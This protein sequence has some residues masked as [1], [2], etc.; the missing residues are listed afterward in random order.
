MVLPT[1][2]WERKET[3]Q[4]QWTSSRYPSVMRDARMGSTGHQQSCSR[5]LLA[6]R[7]STYHYRMPFVQSYRQRS[8]RLGWASAT[9]PTR[10]TWLVSAFVRRVQRGGIACQDVTDASS[11]P[12]PSWYN[13]VRRIR[14]S[15]SAQPPIAPRTKRPIIVWTRSENT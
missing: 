11:I 13:F 7:N 4:M 14:G 12:H 2:T 6:I 15:S 1:V 9:K 8:P 10:N 3:A 5:E